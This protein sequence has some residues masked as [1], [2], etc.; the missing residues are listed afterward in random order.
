MSDTTEHGET[1]VQHQQE[2]NNNTEKPSSTT[3]EHNDNGYVVVS[4]QEPSTTATTTTT[5]EETIEQVVDVALA[6]KEV[7]KEVIKEAAAHT[8]DTTTS[9]DSEAKNG[10]G[11]SWSG[12][13]LCPYY[14]LGLKC[15]NKIEISPRVK[16]LILWRDPRYT[17]A[18]FSSVLVLLV[19]LASF[20][21]ITVVST[22]LLLALIVVGSYRLYAAVIYRIKGSY[23]DTLDKI[24]ALDISI[25]HDKLEQVVRRLEVDANTTLK[26]LK[27]LVL[28]DSVTHSSIAI[29]VLYV[30]H[31]IGAIFNTSTLIILAFVGVFTLPKVYEVYHVE[32]D[33]V[34]AKVAEKGHILGRQVHAKLPFL[35]KRKTD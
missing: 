13:S 19:S 10:Q 3:T 7:I 1:F 12:F 6:T 2:L 5:I 23:D 8:V 16:D 28:W 21:L 30:I 31:G 34:L 35:H 17:G 33:R 20:S 32:I 26:Q 27:A 15:L 14:F 25:P 24:S 29:A 9:T 4:E 18:I 11:C 22:F